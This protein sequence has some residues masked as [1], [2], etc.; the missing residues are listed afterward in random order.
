MA[1]A[2]GGG[3]ARRGGEG[4][5]AP[6][7]RNPLDDGPW[8][9]DREGVSA[10]AVGTIVLHLHS[11]EEEEATAPGLGRRRHLSLVARV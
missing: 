3:D 6:Y 11:V 1:A 4:G 8:V 2:V 10:A 7:G 5:G 9:A